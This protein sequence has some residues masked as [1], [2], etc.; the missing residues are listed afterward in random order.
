[1]ALQQ[2]HKRIVVADVEGMVA[3][4]GA[5]WA[6]FLVRSV[7]RLAERHGARVTL[8]L[9]PGAL[10]QPQLDVILG[11]CGT[12]TLDEK[13]KRAAAPSASGRMMPRAAELF[14]VVAG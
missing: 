13:L 1:M 2:G 4:V 10:S 12:S 5:A 6:A 7:V 8:T 3:S 14:G 9:N 11:S